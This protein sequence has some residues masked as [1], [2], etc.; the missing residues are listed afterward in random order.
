MRYVDHDPVAARRAAE[1]CRDRAVDYERIAAQVGSTVTGVAWWGPERD[2]V[3][4]EVGAVCDDLRHEAASLRRSADLLE[5]AAR[6]A[7]QREADLADAARRAEEARVAAADAAA[8]HVLLSPTPWTP[9]PTPPAP[10]P[11]AVP[12]GVQ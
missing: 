4:R 8:L 7:E 12:V 1:V 2:R 6:A 10:Q 11:P 3:V 5:A 9:P